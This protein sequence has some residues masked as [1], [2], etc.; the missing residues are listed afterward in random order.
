MVVKRRPLTNTVTVR[1]LTCGSRCSRNVRLCPRTQAFVDGKTNA[2]AAEM[3]PRLCWLDASVP[4]AI[5]A[6]IA[7][8]ATVTATRRVTRLN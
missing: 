1:Q 5:A 8:T 3:G 6:A 7:V 4:A 2:D